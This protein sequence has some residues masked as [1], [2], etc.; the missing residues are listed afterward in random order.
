MKA[1]RSAVYHSEES[2]VASPVDIVV[3]AVVVEAG[4]ERGV[5]IC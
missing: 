2:V 3:I 4:E 1:Q 5:G